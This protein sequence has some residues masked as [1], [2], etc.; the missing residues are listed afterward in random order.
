M[1]RP[2]HN[3]EGTSVIRS[4]LSRLSQEGLSDSRFE[5][6]THGVPTGS[7]QVL[8]HNHPL[9]VAAPIRVTSEVSILSFSG[10]KQKTSTN[11]PNK[12]NSKRFFIAVIISIQN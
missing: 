4:T 5:K 6:R 10:F 2:H 12:I 7:R 9:T 11:K 1:K 8:Y 3:V